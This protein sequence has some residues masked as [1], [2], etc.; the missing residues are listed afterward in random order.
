[1]TRI[2]FRDMSMKIACF[3]YLVYTSRPYFYRRIFFLQTKQYASGRQRGKAMRVQRLCES[4]SA[5]NDNRASLGTFIIHRNLH[6]SIDHIIASTGMYKTNPKSSQSRRKFH[7]MHKIGS[8]MII[9]VQV[10]SGSG[11]S[12]ISV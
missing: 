11:S 8:V 9:L 4:R 6:Y 5:E 7:I 10:G 12:G 1:M 3:L 2:T